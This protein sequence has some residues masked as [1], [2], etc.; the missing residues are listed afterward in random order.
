MGGKIGLEYIEKE[1]GGWKIE[2]G[3]CNDHEQTNEEGACV[4]EW[5]RK[6]SRV[7][8]VFAWSAVFIYNLID[9]Y[10]KVG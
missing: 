5:W 6:L 9:T 1:K 8:I 10:H 4:Y 7:G 2:C 3:F